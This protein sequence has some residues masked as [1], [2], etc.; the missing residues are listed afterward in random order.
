M[1]TPAE[2]SLA[3]RISAH[4]S[5]AATEDRTARTENARAA[6]KAKFTE[7][8]GGDPVRGE[9]LR[10]A[11]YQRLALKSARSRRLAKE[12]MAAAIEAEAEL[13]TGD[14]A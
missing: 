8:A 7:Q 11:Y 10:K 3:A 4:E 2:R 12:L 5:W 9:H 6:L 14:S 1:A 13:R